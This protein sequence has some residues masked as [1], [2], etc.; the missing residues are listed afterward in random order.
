MYWTDWGESPMIA[1]SGM[2]GSL[3]RKFITQDIHWPNG[4]YVDYPGQRIYWVDAK[5]QQVESVRLDASDRRVSLL[6]S[7]VFN[8]VC[9]ACI[10]YK[11]EKIIYEIS[12]GIS[13]LK[14]IFKINPL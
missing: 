13:I 12:F 14:I 5:I 4:I 3:P 7:Q 6:F 8:N 9:A 11:V 1:R 2:D 10:L